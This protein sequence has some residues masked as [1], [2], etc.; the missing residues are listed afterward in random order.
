MKESDFRLP[1]ST[2]NNRTRGYRVRP[3]MRVQPRYRTVPASISQPVTT[4]LDGV[5]P[6][7]LKST[8]IPKASIAPPK[9]V[10]IKEVSAQPLAA[11][12]PQ[13]TYRHRTDVARSHILL[14]DV[15]TLPLGKRSFIS[16]SVQRIKKTSP[17]KKRGIALALA[18]ALLLVIGVAVN[19]NSM[20]VTKQI[21]AQA[22]KGDGAA[23]TSGRPNDSSA[24]SEVQPDVTAMNKY[25]VAADMPKYVTI[26]SLN[27]WSRVMRVGVDAK[28]Q[29]G[30]PKNVYDTAWYDGSAKPGQPG[31]AFIDGHVLGPTKGGVFANLSKIK[32]GATVSVTMGDNTKYSY[33]VVATEK[34]DANS[35]DMQKVL[36]PYGSAQ[37]SLVLMTCSG[38]YLKG[39]ETFDKRLIVYAVRE[40]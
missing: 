10:A 1:K 23:D 28:S 14:P 34:V 39:T 32:A 30:T 15:P 2:I 20:K 9:S 22:A 40:S 36:K 7:P 19:V 25:T 3:V 21:E 17:K 38:T 35:I 16:K 6:V 33:K 8:L 5:K 13:S 31:T 27:V 26:N 4:V 29:I 18:A 12:Q 11:H 24:Y 37:Q